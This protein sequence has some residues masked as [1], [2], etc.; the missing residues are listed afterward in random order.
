ML[1]R[2]AQ[3]E[4]IEE[5]CRLEE[6][7]FPTE[8]WSRQMFAEELANDLAL[9]VVAEETDGDPAGSGSGSCRRGKIAGYLIAW[10]IAPVECQIGSIA[11]LPE[12]RRRG[13]A[14]E[15]LGILTEVC[16]RTGTGEIYL[17]VRVSNTPAI[18]L[19]RRFGFETDGR[20]E[21]YYQDGEDAYTMARI[22]KAGRSPE[23]GK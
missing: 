1:Y 14:S 13:V 16:S 22:E 3:P 2:K 10:V 18:E 23:E 4:D 9:F 21:K 19:Y 15:L 11:V 6:I 5:L 17:E 20:R 8:P 7:C 12:Y